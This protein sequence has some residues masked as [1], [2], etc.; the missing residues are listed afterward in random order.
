M[1]AMNGL[2]TVTIQ[3]QQYNLDQNGQL[4]PVHQKHH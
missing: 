2:Q 4:Y 3:G 1:A